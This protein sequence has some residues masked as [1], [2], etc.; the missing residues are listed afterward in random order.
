MSLTRFMRDRDGVV[1]ELYLNTY[2]SGQSYWGWPSGH[3]DAR[4]RLAK[5]AP[6]ATAPTCLVCVREHANLPEHVRDRMLAFKDMIVR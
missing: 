6:D 3:V 2:V 1:H 4:M 5:P